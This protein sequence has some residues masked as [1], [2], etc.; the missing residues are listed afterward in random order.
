MLKDNR[1]LESGPS[2]KSRIN[3]LGHCPL[4]WQLTA[5]EGIFLVSGIRGGT[6]MKRL[7]CVAVLC[8]LVSEVE[9]QT[10][11]ITSCGLGSG[12]VF[13]QRVP[14]GNFGWYADGFG[15]GQQLTLLQT[16]ATY[17]LITKDALSTFSAKEQGGTVEMLPSSEDGIFTVTVTYSRGPTVEAYMF[18]LDPLGSGVLMWTQLKNALI[19]PPK[20]AAFTGRCSK[21][22]Q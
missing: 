17:D 11:V 3:P 15:D 20:A 2:S 22:T 13:S 9:A 14:G 19:L 8:C 6:P 16:G 12:Q 1:A 4:A 18:I 21:T 10:R 7:L 5:L